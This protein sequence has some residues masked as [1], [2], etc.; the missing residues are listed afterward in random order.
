MNRYQREIIY[1]P[2]SRNARRAWLI[3]RFSLLVALLTALLLRYHFI[4]ISEAKAVF[5][6]IIA[7]CV[8]SCVFAVLAFMQIWR[9][10]NRGLGKAVSGFVLAL[11]I[12]GLPLALSLYHAITPGSVEA[13]T[14]VV[15]PPPFSRSKAAFNLRGNW[16]A[17]QPEREA[18]DRQAEDNPDII[19]LILDADPR[20]ITQQ[21][22]EYA[23]EHEW[24]MISNI[25][26]GGRFGNGHLD[27]IAESSFLHLPIDV[28][29]RIIPTATGARVD[30]RS[31][32]RYPAFDSTNNVELV[33]EL[34]ENL[35]KGPPLG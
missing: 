6:A 10:D 5:F 19:S 24:K 32:S 30:I 26:V 28:T 15:S 33:R 1:R 25:A 3:A 34:M 21:I 29:A 35:L 7:M 18:L 16:I 22:Q 23:H 31:A 14:D 2:H 8:I 27:F 12:M 13:T 4:S 9:N 17:A 11:A 20:S